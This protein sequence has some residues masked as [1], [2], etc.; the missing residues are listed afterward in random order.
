MQAIA[1][2]EQVTM[3]KICLMIGLNVEELSTA[4]SH[5]LKT[6]IESITNVKHIVEERD[7]YEAK[8]KSDPGAKLRPFPFVYQKIGNVLT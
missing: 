8:R 6:I 3:K 7:K 2:L 5:V 1:I 4:A